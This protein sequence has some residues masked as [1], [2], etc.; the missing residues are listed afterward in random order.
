VLN[1]NVLY[2]DC[3][4]VE[5]QSVTVIIISDVIVNAS[6]IEFSRCRWLS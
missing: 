1:A 3:V 4:W 5:K 6:V 2:F